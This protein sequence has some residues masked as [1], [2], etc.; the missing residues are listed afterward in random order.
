M[1]RL[2]E[3]MD[4]TFLA[5][6]TK[7]VRDLRAEIDRARREGRPDNLKECLVE[8]RSYFE[9]WGGGFYD[10]LFGHGNDNIPDEMTAEDANNAFR[11]LLDDLFF[12]LLFWDT[13]KEKALKVYR[14]AVRV[15]RKMEDETHKRFLKDNPEVRSEH[16]EWVKLQDSKRL[17]LGQYY[18]WGSPWFREWSDLGKLPPR[19]ETP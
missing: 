1:D 15:F 14:K 12:N 18:H 10:I 17:S 5:E 2:A 11:G 3:F 6:S 4:K 7:G 13:E 19:Q 16:P 9:G 8:L